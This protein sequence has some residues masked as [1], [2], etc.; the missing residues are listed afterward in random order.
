VVYQTCCRCKVPKELFE[1]H[2]NMLNRL[3]VE[4]CCKVCRSQK[5]KESKAKKIIKLEEI[6]ITEKYCSKCENTLEISNFWKSTCMK[7]GYYKYCKECGKEYIKTE[8]VKIEA[9][10]FKKCV[11]CEKM[12]NKEEF[13][14]NFKNIDRLNETCI[15]C[16][17]ISR[18]R[19]RIK[20]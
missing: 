7:D 1:Y 4:Y 14:R 17:K 20:K 2:R 3:K 19:N 16:Y 18:S 15:S 13:R 11:T 12:K 6:K 5:A 8:K 10:E 9:P